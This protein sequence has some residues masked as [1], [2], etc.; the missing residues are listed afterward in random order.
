MRK[1]FV[2]M[3]VA[4]LAA[5]TGFADVSAPT[6]AGDYL[7]DTHSH[8][9]LGRDDVTWSGAVTMRFPRG[10]GDSQTKS[11]IDAYG[12]IGYFLTDQIELECTV[13]WYSADSSKIVSAGAG[14]NYYFREL[15]DNLYPYVGAG[16]S[17]WGG[18][19]DGTDLQI[20]A[21]FR[22]YLSDHMGFR[23]WA[24]YDSNPY[25]ANDGN[26]Q[27]AVYLGIFAHPY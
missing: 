27:F 16:V 3:A 10:E 26:G 2:M 24:Q 1:I 19:G 15:V 25:G 20:K 7:F 23:Y 9:W 13:E 14:L 22:H 12:A 11:F 5:N 8:I 17:R 21:G 4:C 6:A 18:D